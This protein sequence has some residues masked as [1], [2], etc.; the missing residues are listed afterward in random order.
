MYIKSLI[1]SKTYPKSENIRTISFKDGLNLIVD[2]TNSAKG[3]GIGKTTTLRLIDIC[4]GAKDRKYIYFDD[5]LSQTNVA[6]KDFIHDNKVQAELILSDTENGDTALSLKVD[7]FERGNRYIDDDKYNYEDYCESLG[8][9]FFGLEAAKPTYKQ[10]MN[11]FV[12]INQK[13]DNDKFIKF[14]DTHT[15]SEEYKNVYSFLFRLS[16]IALAEKVLSLS[17][18]IKALK[19]DIK[20]IK[21]LNSIT[22]IGALE[23]LLVSLDRDIVMLKSKRDALV[24]INELKKNEDILADVRSEYSLL[25]EA[26][27]SVGFKIDRYQKIVEETRIEQEH[28]V[29]Q[30]TL[31]DLYAEVSEGFEGLTKSFND[32]LDFNLKLLQN[33]I[34][35][36][37]NSIGAEKLKLKKLL[38]ERQ[39]L[40]KKYEDVVVLIK[41]NDVDSYVDVQGSIESK[42]QEKG[43]LQKIIDLHQTFVDEL[44]LAEAEESDLKDEPQ[45]DP[46]EQIA[47]FNEYFEDYSRKVTSEEYQLY[48]IAEGFPLGVQSRGSGLSTGTKKS[49]ISAFDLAYQSFAKDEHIRSP[50]FV[51][52]DV[53]ETMD[54]PG[55]DNVIAI[56]KMIGCQYIVAVLY[57]KIKDSEMVSDSDVILELSEDNKLFLV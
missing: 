14:L 11:M 39:D 42:F 28:S 26:I 9:Y 15:T 31:G 41:N 55:L 52:H 53:I 38:K 23:Q 40:L 1:I 32:L 27:D 10:L 48:P 5:E 25:A 21:K 22:S 6:L 50:R 43:K 57:Q 54:G 13:H 24:N 19:R 34:T 56:T 33:K 3:N 49:V 18:K 8:S 20:R 37:E 44:K 46:K 17:Q 36:F 29:D 45:R 7:L 35:F 12:R 16:N 51:V 47:K 30:E 4:L 2:S